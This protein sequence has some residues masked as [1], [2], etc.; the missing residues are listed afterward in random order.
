VKYSKTLAAV[1]TA[2]FALVSA[3]GIAAQENVGSSA[4]YIYVSNSSNNHS[5]IYAYSAAGNGQLT[6]ITGSPF[7]TSGITAMAL[8]EKWLFGTN[9]V[10]LYSFSI[11]SGGALHQVSSVNAQ[12]HNDPGNCGGPISLFLDHTGSTLYDGDIYANICANNGYQY[13][14]LD[15]HNGALSFSGLN[16]S[17]TVQYGQP[18]SFIANNQYAYGG[19]C[20]HGTP[21]IFGFKRNGNGTLTAL[22]INPELPPASQGE[23]CPNLAAADPSNHIAISL[24]PVDDLTQ[25]GPPQIGVYTADN[26][27]NLT[28]H[29][30]A[31]N[32][33]MSSV[34]NVQA[35]SMA[36]SGALLA[37]GGSAGLQVF[38]FNGANPATEYTG[39][40]TNDSISQV[41]WD[42]EN[43]LYALST[44]G[45]KL[46]VFTVTT[47]TYSQAPGSPYTITSPQ[48]LIVLPKS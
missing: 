13:W 45:N 11:A 17:F 32:M 46:F 28:T 26:S 4:A 20:Y 33:P 30:T 47:T 36:P 8:N 27:G 3:T 16:P 43:H 41:F 14:G 5:Q 25:V 21:D 42:K 2:L 12:I 37:V 38:H 23:Y 10:N 7:P 9:G 44:P 40:L 1:C 39:L 29:S 34:S 35:M 22:N 6:P 15:Q 31:A 18:L 24:T 19:A 48:S